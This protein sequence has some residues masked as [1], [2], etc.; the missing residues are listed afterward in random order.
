MVIFVDTSA[1]YAL[2][3]AGDINHGPA[4]AQWLQWVDGSINFVVTNY[5]LLE[6]SA[7][8]QRRLGMQ[9]F[10]QFHD[11]LLPTMDVFWVS[12]KI[13]RQAMQMLLAADRRELSQ[14]DCTSFVVMNELGIQK[15]FTFDRHFVQAG[16]TVLPAI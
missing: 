14:V 6:T 8:V 12:E 15:A 10:R 3:N 2:L 16:F 11:L 4:K 1:I 5:V 9:S 13:H 7:L